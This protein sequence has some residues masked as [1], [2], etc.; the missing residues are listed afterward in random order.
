[1]KEI[2]KI[3]NKI[4]QLLKDLLTMKRFLEID[5]GQGEGYFVWQFKNT[6]EMAN[7]YY[8]LLTN[9]LYKFNN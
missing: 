4:D 5:S 9:I 3:N 1:M 2:E 6:K 7:Y 8:L